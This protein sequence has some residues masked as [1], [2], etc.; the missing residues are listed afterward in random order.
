MRWFRGHAEAPRLLRL[1][2]LRADEDVNETSY[3]FRARSRCRGKSRP[4]WRRD[5]LVEG[6]KYA[7][8]D[9]WQPRRSS[10]RSS[11]LFSSPPSSPRRRENRPNSCKNRL[12]CRAYTRL[13]VPSRRDTWRDSNPR[14]HPECGDYDSTFKLSSRVTRWKARIGVNWHYANLRECALI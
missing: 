10:R 12:A 13:C 5:H 7:R 1:S 8:R 14:F 3:H 2:P 11:R 4:K 6:V 9:T